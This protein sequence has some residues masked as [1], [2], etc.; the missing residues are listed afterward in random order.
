MNGPFSLYA[1]VA[2]SVRGIQMPAAT[3]WVVGL[4]HYPTL[5]IRTIGE[6]CSLFVLTAHT[7]VGSADPLPLTQE[8]HH[9]G[10]TNGSRSCRRGSC[11][12][13]GGLVPG[14]DRGLG[15]SARRRLRRVIQRR[16]SDRTRRWRDRGASARMPGAG[17]DLKF[18]CAA[19]TYSINP[20]TASCGVPHPHV[21]PNR[22]PASI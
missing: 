1:A 11:A 4:T 10:K 2:R 7:V 20:W 6:L 16:L 5:D 3:T 9:T 22:H 18:L 13:L 12:Y 15:A 21:A 19:G 17:S 8:R 14:H